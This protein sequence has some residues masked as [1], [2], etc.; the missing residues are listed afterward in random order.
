MGGHHFTKDLILMLT[1]FDKT[2]KTIIE[3]FPWII[4]IWWILIYNLMQLGTLNLILEHNWQIIIVDS[5]YGDSPREVKF[6]LDSKKKHY[7]YV[8]M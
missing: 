8:I 2:I 5:C 6:C 3:N 4:E 7:Y 1:S